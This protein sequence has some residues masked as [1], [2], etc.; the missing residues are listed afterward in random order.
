MKIVWWLLWRTIAV[1]FLLFLTYQ[2][3]LA[4]QIVWWRNHNP[5][6]SAFMDSR[7]SIMQIKDPKAKLKH[8][9]IN[10]RNSLVEEQIF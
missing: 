5:S 9:W 10:Y 8:K 4:A 3:W 2:V 6:T 7:L 1:I